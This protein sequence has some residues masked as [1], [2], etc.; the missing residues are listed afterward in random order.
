MVELRGTRAVPHVGR[1]Y[2][3]FGG[4]G[5]PV[6]SEGRSRL[7]KVNQGCGELSIWA[8]RRLCLLLESGVGGPQ[9]RWLSPE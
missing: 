1:N 8:C 6:W 5:A 9:A 3:R 2:E 4:C 7:V